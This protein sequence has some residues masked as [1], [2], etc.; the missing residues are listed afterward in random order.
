MRNDNLVEGARPSASWGT[1]LARKR[2]ECA[3]SGLVQRVQCETTTVGERQRAEVKTRVLRAADESCRE[4]V[5]DTVGPRWLRSHTSV[6][7]KY[8]SKSEMTRY[9]LTIQTLIPFLL[10]V[11]T[12]GMLGFAGCRP[13]GMP[14]AR[15]SEV[16]RQYVLEPIPPSVKNIRAHQP[17][18][19]YGKRYTLR[20]NINRDDLNLIVNSRPFIRVRNVEYKNGSLDWGWGRLDADPLLIPEGS[21]LDV[22]KYNLGISLYGRKRGP[23]WFRP[24]LWDDPEAYCFYREGDL[25]NTEAYEREMRKSSQLRR[26]RHI[27]QVLLYNEKEGEAYFV[28][29]DTPR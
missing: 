15:A 4:N 13:R 7:S 27:I 14:E 10:F 18:R 2:T 16:F 20:F 12:V 26:G 19:F 6:G 28:A 22:P 21:P 29:L 25:V 9:K 3:C 24:D 8:R 23:A 5:P 11:F 17:G 1:L